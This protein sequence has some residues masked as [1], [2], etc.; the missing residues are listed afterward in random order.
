[1]P[2]VFLYFF[3]N[4]LDIFPDVKKIIDKPQKYQHISIVN[5]TKNEQSFI[6]LKKPYL[7]NDWKLCNNLNSHLNYTKINSVDPKQ[8]INLLFEVDTNEF[9]RIAICKITNSFDF[10]FKSIFIQVP[11]LKYIIFASEFVMNA[12]SK[13]IRK[14]Y[15]EDWLG[16]SYNLTFLLL[17]VFLIFH[18]KIQ[19]SWK[20]VVFALLVLLS[21]AVGFLLYN[22]VLYFLKIH[23]II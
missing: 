8:T 2:F 21:L 23:K 5:D 3:S 18:I 17:L 10:P 16:F 1:M 20:Y 22:D 6:V 11:D 14:N 9:N 4:I 15:F 13:I 12:K 7:K 19:G